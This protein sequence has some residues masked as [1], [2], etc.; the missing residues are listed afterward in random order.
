MS[1]LAHLWLPMV[2]SAVLLLVPSGLATAAAFAWPC[3]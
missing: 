3:R 1:F 2:A